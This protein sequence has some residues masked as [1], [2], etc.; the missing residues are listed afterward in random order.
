MRHSWRSPQM[1]C[2]LRHRMKLLRDKNSS[3]MQYLIA[4]LNLFEYLRGFMIIKCIMKR[5]PLKQC[6]CKSYCRLLLTIIWVRRSFKLKRKP[7]ITNSKQ[8]I[9]TIFHTTVNQLQQAKLT[10]LL[11][12]KKIPMKTQL[13]KDGKKR[14][15]LT[16]PLTSREV[17]SIKVSNIT[18]L[19]IK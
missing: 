10:Y 6:P 16:I 13:S 15:N 4:T 9:R 17:F 5:Y 18:P 19:K 14:K 1:K 11:P 3:R 12:L 2:R 7:L 8:N